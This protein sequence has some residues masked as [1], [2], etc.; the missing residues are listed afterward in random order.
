MS[1][2][3]TV[4]TDLGAA[5]ADGSAPPTAHDMAEV[6]KFQR[7][8]GLAGLP[9]GRDDGWIPRRAAGW[10]PYVIGFSFEPPEGMDDVHPTAWGLPA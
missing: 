3:G 7:F 6:R 8:L 10:I 1:W 5:L 2:R 9:P 4:A